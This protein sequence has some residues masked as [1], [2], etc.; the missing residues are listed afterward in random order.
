MQKK[1][2]IS[3]INSTESEVIKMEFISR[4][5]EIILT[6]EEEDF[7]KKALH[8]LDEITS[9]ISDNTAIDYCI[10]HEL[11][12]CFDNIYTDINTI[13]DFVMEN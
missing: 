7:L 2:G 13:E 9:Q 3:G 5:T 12:D 6:D 1:I 8:I 10:N 4:G 11:M